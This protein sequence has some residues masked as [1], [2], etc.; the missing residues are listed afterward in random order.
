M[1]LTPIISAIITAG[2]AIGFNLYLIKIKREDRIRRALHER[3]EEE[4]LNPDKAEDSALKHITEVFMESNL[5][6]YYITLNGSNITVHNRLNK[7][8]Q[9]LTVDRI[10]GASYIKS[11]HKNPYFH[12]GT[13]YVLTKKNPGTDAISEFNITT[14]N[15]FEICCLLFNGYTPMFFSFQS[16]SRHI[17]IIKYYIGYFNAIH[18]SDFSY[19]RQG[20]NNTKYKFIYYDSNLYVVDDMYMW[21]V[22]DGVLVQCGVIKDGVVQIIYNRITPLKL[23]C[24]GKISDEEENMFSIFINSLKR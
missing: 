11:F 4:L 15:A 10:N 16:H 18:S 20:I 9:S 14:G 24:S 3:I 8:E 22:Y 17:D 2:L 23:N 1:D 6:H 21:G 5:V 12:F 13:P 7:V 19:G